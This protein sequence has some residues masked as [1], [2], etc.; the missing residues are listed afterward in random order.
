ME[1]GHAAA[2]TIMKAHGSYGSSTM[3]GRAFLLQARPL[4]QTDAE[5]RSIDRLSSRID[6]LRK[7]QPAKITGRHMY[8]KA[9]REQ[10]SFFASTGKRYDRNIGKVVMKGHGARWKALSAQR[11]RQFEEQ[12][13][14]FK[15]HRR[16]AIKERL[17]EAQEELKLRKQRLQE[18]MSK[19]SLTTMSACR[20]SDKDLVDF[21]QVCLVPEWTT[22]RLEQMTL[23]AA[24]KV[25][26]PAPEVQAVLEAMPLEM[27]DRNTK[28]PSWLS[29]VCHNRD[30]LRECIVRTTQD[31]SYN[32][33]RFIFALQSPLLVCICEVSL[34]D[35]VQ[36]FF[37]PREYDQKSLNTW[38]KL[39]H[40][41]WTGFVFSDTGIFDEAA[42][43]HVLSGVVNL[44]DHKMGS[45][46]DWVLIEALM[47]SLPGRSSSTSEE[48][49]ASRA[50]KQ[51]DIPEHLAAHPNFW[52]VLTDSGP[53]SGMVVEPKP[54]KAMPASSDESS[55]ED[56]ELDELAAMEELWAT[57]HELGL[58]QALTEQWFP[59]SLRG[60]A[61]TASKKGVAFDCFLAAGKRSEIKAWC[62]NYRVAASGSFS[63]AKYGMDLAKAL[64]DEWATRQACLYSM[65]M[66]RGA[67]DSFVF[68]EADYQDLP[69]CEAA[70]KV[71]ASG[72]PQAI[73][74]L[75]QIRAAR[76][77]TPAGAVGA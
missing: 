52:Q 10:A 2:S 21:D 60:G 9:M 5:V 71:V 66:D 48:P 3:Q 72:H 16:E 4:F 42:Q 55:S 14:Q 8:M 41:D 40:W 58:D 12:A 74:R 44:D 49:K 20:L 1:Q 15:E 46:G 30:F 27:P 65:W 75:R 67:S 73:E 77:Q 62:R 13:V 47:I 57:R 37:H 11:R 70:E 31:G 45:D 33:Y 76:L 34:C 38:D 59:V 17:C 64:A 53:S 23:A 18:R 32:H 28:P 63:I 51:V 6:T 36:T 19:Q 7:S 54:D 68:R 39:F 25:G 56:D 69:S 35:S 50:H 24:Q 43:V 61:W 29:W 22:G 26:P